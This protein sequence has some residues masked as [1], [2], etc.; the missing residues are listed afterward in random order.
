MKRAGLL[1]LL[2][3][4]LCTG[5]VRQ[6]ADLAPQPTA[7][8]Q[9]QTYEPLQNAVMIAAAPDTDALG[10]P[11]MGENHYDQYVLFRDLRV[12]SYH[13]GTFLDGLCINS[14]P[15]ALA[16]TVQI[17]YRDK[18][19][20]ELARAD[21]YT[22]QTDRLLLQ[23]GENRIYAEIYTDMEVDSLEFEMEILEHFLPTVE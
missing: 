1:L 10:N 20:V 14:Y 22:V 19:G 18:D 23:S 13:G 3:L 6:S 15:K 17:F 4:L 9:V 2:L 21:L 12:Y 5:C 8:P 16:G 11:L 7:A